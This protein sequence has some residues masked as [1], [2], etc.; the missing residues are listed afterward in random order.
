M[1]YLFVK[2]FWYV[3]AAFAIGL[4]VGWISCARTAR[5][6]VGRTGQRTY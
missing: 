6:Q 2:L 3:L 1:D 5:R 4:F